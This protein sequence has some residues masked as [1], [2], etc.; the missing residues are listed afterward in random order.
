MPPARGV[1]SYIMGRARAAGLCWKLLRAAAVIAGTCFG[2]GGKEGPI[3]D[4]YKHA[5]TRLN[6][7]NGSRKER[8]RQAFSQRIAGPT[9][10][11]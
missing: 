8:V 11:S 10:E 2:R 1:V 4:T 7:S 3:E 5:H 9:N 6:Q